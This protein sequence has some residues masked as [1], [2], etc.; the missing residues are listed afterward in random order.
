MAAIRGAPLGMN[1]LAVG[2]GALKH[3]RKSKMTLNASLYITETKLNASH[4]GLNNI[5]K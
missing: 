4:E 2:F 3:K 1:S 5:L